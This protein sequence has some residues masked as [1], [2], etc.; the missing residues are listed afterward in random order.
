MRIGICDDERKIQELLGEKVRQ[1]YPQAEL[2]FYNSGEELLEAGEWPQ[3]LLLDIQ[4]PGPNG[5]E[6]ARCLRKQ[7][8][9]MILIF[10]TA[11][12]DY[13]FQAFDVGA[14]HYLV[15][16]FS[17]AKL[18]E[19]LSGAVEQYRKLE[20][21]RR[22]AASKQTENSILVK[23]GGCHTR[24]FW[25][26]IIYAE[27]FNRKVTIHSREGD[28]EYYGRL[29]DLE[30]QLG[31]DFYRSHRAYLVHFKYVEK[32]TASVIELERGTALMAKQNYPD[33]VKQ[34]LAYNRRQGQSR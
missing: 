3:I 12:E 14:F 20:E 33:F 13:V 32:Y 2:F 18:K 26:D 4:M 30:K 24:I 15:K 25:K 10:V 16:P 29:G 23:S 22:E 21:L 7:D 1:L 5:M 19:V 8:R 28:V 9:G 6:I 11:L 27:V 17:D 34:Y 31:E